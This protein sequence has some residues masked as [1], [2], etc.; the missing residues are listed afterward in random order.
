MPVRTK[1]PH[2]IKSEETK[3]KI[4]TT[5]ER[6]LS[7]YDFKFLTVRNI[8]EEAGVAYGSFYHHFSSKEN[9]LFSYTRQ[10]FQENVSANPVP[11][12]IHEDDFIR[13]VLWY[14]EV[15]GF[16]CE[17][18]GQDLMGYI[19]KNCEGSLFQETMREQIA[20]LLLSADDRG[21]IDHFRNTNGRRAVDLLVKDMEILCDG[22]LMWWSST[23]DE[24]EPLH[25]TLEHLCFNMLFSFCSD[26][27]RKAEF[28][29]QLL[30]ELER[31]DGAIT[32]H[33]VP[34]NK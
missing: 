32:I 17:A 1:L 26:Q 14:V 15:L 19:Y 13:R 20:P 5:M 24:I 16:F 10:L 21:D 4:L 7:E 30:T 6:M 9:L 28:P 18:A 31:F 34:S 11:D 33:G 2:E 23:E 25:E 3:Q 29:H 12:W 22:T 27:F 8:C